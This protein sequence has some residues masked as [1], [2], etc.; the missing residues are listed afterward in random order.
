MLLREWWQGVRL[1]A[2]RSLGDGLRSK[3]VRITTAVLLLVAFAAV[4]GPRLLGDRDQTY[5]LATTGSAS[6]HLRTSLNAAGKAAGF[7]V[8]FRSLHG[9]RAIEAAVRKGDATIG[10]GATSMFVRTD[11]P[12]T[13]TL[14][15]TQAV[16]A[17]Q[18]E[19]ALRS[20]GLTDQEIASV[21]AIAPPKQVV[22][23][24][25]QDE[26]RATVGFLIGIALYMALMFSGNIIAMNVGVEKSTRISEVL[27]AVL[28]PSQILI[29]NV[30]G[31]GIQTLLQLLVLTVPILT[32]LLVTH[33]LDIPRVAAGDIGLGVAWFVIGY[34]MYGF[35]FA[36][37]AALVDKVT[38]VGSAI[39]P[40]TVVLVLAYL[41]AIMGVQQD[42]GSVLSL[43][44]S[45]F[46]LT[47]LMAMPVRW[48]SGLVPGWQLALSMVLAML[49]AVVLAAL[50]SRVYRRALVIT[51]RRLRLREMMTAQ[52][53]GAEHSSGGGA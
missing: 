48:A 30:L 32:A 3:S 29:G 41:G 6:T 13:F 5:T 14:L 23:G 46:P 45:L 17:Q 21:L 4:F 42:P 34:F 50:A 53:N 1:V 12:G 8:E 44:L 7:S 16:V 15:V 26:G 19:Q 10:I 24:P 2:G 28:R 36:A 27:L 25:V 22:V 33:D 38:D 47:S 9:D 51:G 11:A 18:R 37:T 52:A 20:A 49:A 31:I 40:V 35:L 39:M 43:T